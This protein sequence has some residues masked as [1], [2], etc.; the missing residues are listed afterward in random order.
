MYQDLRRDFLWPRM[1]RDV[2]EFV[3]KCLICQ[4][5]T[6]EHQ[7]PAGQL[8]P[9]DVPTW[10]W[11]NV[12]MDFISGLPQTYNN[13][14]S[15]WVIVDRLIKSTYFLVVKTTYPLDKLAREYIREIM[16][17]H[18]VPNSIVSDNDP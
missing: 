2:I 7:R 10:K 3:S 11:D 17:L 18:G 9:L 16:R 13:H 4:K 6:I 8:Q 5:I 12:F 15:I 1:K 14:D